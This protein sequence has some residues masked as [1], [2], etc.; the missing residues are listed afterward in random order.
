MKKFPE[1]ETLLIRH[2]KPKREKT[3]DE[4]WAMMLPLTYAKN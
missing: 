4:M 1:L 2:A 3:P